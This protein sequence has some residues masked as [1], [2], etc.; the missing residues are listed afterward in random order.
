MASPA[1]RTIRTFEDV[2]LLSPTSTDTS[3]E[4]LTSDRSIVAT[5]LRVQSE[6][7]YAV[8]ADGRHDLFAVADRIAALDLGARAL[9]LD[10]VS[11]RGPV[12]PVRRRIVERVAGD[13]DHVRHG[14]SDAEL[15]E[16]A[17]LVVASAAARVAL[18][19]LDDLAETAARDA[20]LQGVRDRVDEVARRLAAAL[21]P[22]LR[23]PATAGPVAAEVFLYRLGLE[24]A[25]A[26]TRPGAGLVPVLRALADAASIGEAALAGRAHP[27]GADLAPLARALGPLPGLV[28]LAI[29]HPDQWQLLRLVLRLAVG[30]LER[31]VDALGMLPAVAPAR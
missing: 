9:A 3:A 11:E 26:G 5:I 19:A 20:R 17:M 13:T 27:E 23:I 1:D 12:G 22:A 14:L 21:P 30:G 28:E 8:A 15:L 31:L 24:A 2:G 16:A 29:A 7:V 25:D 4:L 10:A 6:W 18:S